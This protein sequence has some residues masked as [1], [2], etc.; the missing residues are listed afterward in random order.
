M[1]INIHNANHN[2]MDICAFT[3]F[4]SH[5]A[6]AGKSDR[7]H[8]HSSTTPFRR[9]DVRLGKA[10]KF[11]ILNLEGY[12]V[13]ILI[14]NSI[15]TKRMIIIFQRLSPGEGFVNK[16]WLCSVGEEKLVVRIHPDP[17][18]PNSPPLVDRE[19][20]I[21]ILSVLGEKGLC[22]P[23][24]ARYSIDLFSM[25]KCGSLQKWNMFKTTTL[26]AYEVSLIKMGCV[27][28]KMD[29]NNT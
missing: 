23:V 15:F 9:H 1:G 13:W 6:Q 27:G 16:I 18:H 14:G 2:N 10:V 28:W 26:K 7:R 12:N 4:P 22:Q 5:N 8:S 19:L 11:R 24:Y 29:V 20:E 21:R 25:L 17:D 3:F